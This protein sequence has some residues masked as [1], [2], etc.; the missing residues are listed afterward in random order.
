MHLNFAYLNYADKTD[1]LQAAY[2]M[3]T[4]RG[5]DCYSYFAL[6]KLFF[7]RLGIPNINVVRIENPYRRSKHYWSLVS[8]D[9]GETYY[10]FDCTPRSTT[11]NGTRNFCLV[12][13]A[14]LEEYMIRSPG[15]YIRDMSLYPSTP[16]A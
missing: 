9:G 7:D 2:L 14:Y 12:T 8:V 16:E 15:Y 4:N 1:A 6:S 13:D 11:A 5:G 10:H 3:M